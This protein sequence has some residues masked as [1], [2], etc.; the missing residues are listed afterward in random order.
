MVID[1]INAKFGASVPKANL[2]LYA[3]TGLPITP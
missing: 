1:A 3:A 2:G